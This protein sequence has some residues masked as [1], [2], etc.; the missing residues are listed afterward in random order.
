MPDI[1]I[2][3]AKLERGHP[4]TPTTDRA[5]EAPDGDTEQVPQPVSGQPS[6][7]TDTH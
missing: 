7:N 1:E 4:S 3:G 5:E 2:E 6:I